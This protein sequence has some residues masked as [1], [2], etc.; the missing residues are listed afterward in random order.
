M[1]RTDLGQNI[2]SRISIDVERALKVAE[3]KSGT[4]LSLLENYHKKNYLGAVKNVIDLATSPKVIK[5]LGST[6][7]RT[8]HMKIKGS[9]ADRVN[10]RRPVQN[11]RG[12]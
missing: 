7:A 12:R 11:E 9:H 1:E 5:F 3:E 4:F 2:S 6:A 10:K 8:I